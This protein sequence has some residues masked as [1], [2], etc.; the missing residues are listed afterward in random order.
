MSIHD[1]KPLQ[2]FGEKLRTLREREGLSL[3]KLAT[4]L[5]FKAHVYLAQIE[6]GNKKPSAA[7][8]LK[9]AD[10]FHVPLEQLMRDE[11]ELD[12]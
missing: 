6:Y 3:R 12:E 10:Y 9:V 11:L 4:D 7:L 5:G 2:R 8:I 1:E